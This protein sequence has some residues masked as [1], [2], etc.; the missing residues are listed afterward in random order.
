MKNCWPMTASKMEQ[1]SRRCCRQSWWHKRIYGVQRRNSVVEIL[2]KK[3]CSMFFESMTRGKKS[4][5]ELTMSHCVLSTCG[6][7]SV[8][9]LFYT[10]SNCVQR[11]ANTGGQTAD[12]ISKFWSILLRKSE[13][14]LH[15]EVKQRTASLECKDFI[16]HPIQLWRIVK[17]TEFLVRFV[18]FKLV[19]FLSHV[20]GP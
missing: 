13:V 5:D 7:K 9:I 14:P 8:V 19:S 11:V 12:K 17:N 20:R 6:V 18:V 3:N 16:T 15:I 1:I 10:Q 2:N 4:R